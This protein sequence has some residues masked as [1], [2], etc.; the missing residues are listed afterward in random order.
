MGKKDKEW[1][2]IQKKLKAEFEKAGIIY[3]ELRYQGCRTHIEGFAHTQKRWKMGKWGSEEREANLN[4]VVGA[5]NWC[6]SFIE[7]KPYMT[8]ELRRV[9]ASRNPINFIYD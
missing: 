6:H 4:E 9:I 5:C 1:R 7:G 2:R 8:E 3:C